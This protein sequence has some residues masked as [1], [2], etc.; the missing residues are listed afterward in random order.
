MI[1]LVYASVTNYGSNFSDR[2]LKY[3]GRNVTQFLTSFGFGKNA[4]N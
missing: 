4:N 2:L 1:G 3:A